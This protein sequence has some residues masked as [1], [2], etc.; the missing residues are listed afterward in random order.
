MLGK[1]L[2]PNDPKNQSRP[3]RIN[4]NLLDQLVQIIE[5]HVSLLIVK[6]LSHCKDNMISSVGTCLNLRIRHEKLH[7]HIAHKFYL[8]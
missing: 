2:S 1:N 4:R 8:P 6:V 7:L 3:L 5:P